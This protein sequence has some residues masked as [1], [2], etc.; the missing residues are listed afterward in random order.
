MKCPM[1]QN[2]V[3]VE[4]IAATIAGSPMW[5]RLSASACFEEHY[6][7]LNWLAGEIAHCA[8]ACVDA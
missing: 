7:I 4:T 2:P 5:R 6:P 1:D 3:S 8:A